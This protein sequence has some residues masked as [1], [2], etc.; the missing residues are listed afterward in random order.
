VP[1]AL[2]LVAGIAIIV[3]A[4]ALDASWLLTTALIV[5]LA[6]WLV[7]AIRDRRRAT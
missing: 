5:F 7:F 1:V 6:G 3:V 2:G 4:V